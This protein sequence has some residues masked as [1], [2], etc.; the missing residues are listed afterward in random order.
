MAEVEQEFKEIK[1]SVPWGHVAART[2]GSPTEKRV[3]LI[4]GLLDNVGTFTR[5]MKYLPKKS[6]YY[7]CIDLPGH[8]WSSAFPSWMVIDF[9]DYV[10]SLYFILEALQWDTCI[11]LGHCFGA[12]I[13]L[14]FSIFYSNRIEKIISIDGI[15]GLSSYEKD[16]ITYFQAASELSV[17]DYY[18]KHNKLS[19]TKE[20]ILRAFMTMR[21]TP[22][23]YEAADA[24]FE[25]AVT[26]VNGK[27]I[28][29][30]NIRLKNVPLS[31]FNI[32]QCLK[33]CHR[34]PMIPIYIFVSSHGFIVSYKDHKLV[35]EIMR[36]KSILEVIYVD[37]NHDVHNNEPEK[38]APFICKILNSNNSK[39]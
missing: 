26:E 37:G 30:R 3:L 9:V 4:H 14:G 16:F 12:Q 22:L 11:I 32:D 23:N 8:G 27:Y 38:I 17:K 25:R 1:L 5:L 6:F 31:S 2:Y 15:F 35:F 33:L 34:L 36:A 19:F 7:V 21:T 10:H 28:Y 13:A 24:M 29:N 39:L 18:Q 20:E